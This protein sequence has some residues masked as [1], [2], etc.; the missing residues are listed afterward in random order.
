[1][2]EFAA[3]F[4]AS[5]DFDSAEFEPTTDDFE[6]KYTETE[7]AEPASSVCERFQA[8]KDSVPEWKEESLC[9]TMHNGELMTYF[10]TGHNASHEFYIGTTADGRVF[11]GAHGENYDYLENLPEGMYWQEPDIVKHEG[12]YTSLFRLASELRRNARNLFKEQF[13]KDNM[14]T[15]YSYSWVELKPGEAIGYCGHF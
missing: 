14:V 8:I 10:V 3:M 5:Y 13:R 4:Q 2:S 12:K 1:M 15:Y 11:R 9:A 7:W 6:P